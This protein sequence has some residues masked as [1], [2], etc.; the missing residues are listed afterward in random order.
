MLGH[1]IGSFF[2]SIF[3]LL[4]WKSK[5]PFTIK[6][7]VAMVWAHTIILWHLRPNI[8]RLCFCKIGRNMI[9]KWK[10][11]KH[12]N[13]FKMIANI[14]HNKKRRKKNYRC[15]CDMELP[16]MHLSFKSWIYNIT[17]QRIAPLKLFLLL[18][19]LL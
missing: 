14:T 17:N 7:K 16:H 9:N 2:L 11:L 6:L 18:Y 8:E 12:W 13:F 3:V 5:N 4:G 1:L 15:I 10:T 19:L